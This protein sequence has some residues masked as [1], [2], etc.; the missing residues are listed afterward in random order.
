MIQLYPTN[1]Y[2]FLLLTSSSKKGTIPNP[3]SNIGSITK[4]WQ[5]IVVPLTQHQYL[6][7]WKQDITSSP[8]LASTLISPI[9]HGAHCSLI[10]QTW[11][12]DVP[13]PP[14][15]VNSS[16]HS[17]GRS[18]ANP[19]LNFPLIPQAD[20]NR[21]TTRYEPPCRGSYK[22]CNFDCGVLRAATRIYYSL[23]PWYQHI[24][25]W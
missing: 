24:D 8:L 18:Q 10:S 4:S 2:V 16:S 19:L 22:L 9:V 13:W 21:H 11:R 17:R 25:S 3:Y 5:V 1:L 14:H 20:Q 15:L 23:H 12:Q 7:P 6:P